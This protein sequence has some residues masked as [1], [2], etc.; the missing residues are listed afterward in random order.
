MAADRLFGLTAADVSSLAALQ[1][2]DNRPFFRDVRCAQDMGDYDRIPAFRGLREMYEFFTGDSEVSGIFNRR[3]LPVE[4]RNR[5]D[6]TSATFSFVMGN[7]L[8]RRLVAVYRDVKYREELLISIKKTVKD[9]RT[10]EAV[11][12]GGFPD[13]SDVD[14]EAADYVE[15][16]GVTD[17]ESTYTILQKGNLLII[18]RKVIINDDISVVQRL[19]NGLGRSARRSHGK[20]VWNFFINNSNCSDGTAWFT[21]PHGNLGGSALTHATALIAYVALAKMAEKDSGERIGLLDDPGVKPNLIG[22]IDLMTTI[23]Q[24]ATEDY[25]YTG[26]ADLT[27]KTPNPLRGKV[28]PV[29]LSL[30]TDTDDWGMILPPAVADVVEMGYLNG[31]EEPE[32]FVAD[33]PQSEQIFMA[34]KVRYK[35]RHEYAGAVI[36]FRPGY[37]AVV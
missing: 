32:M 23:E 29:V 21:N 12:V 20:Y 26:A 9:F 22:P 16:A 14:P 3:N 4:L 35:I 11:L 5:Q 17:E 30:L 8:A 31:R 7:T 27:T 19:V 10:Q 28:N 18:N 33:S 1:T 37:K 24:I 25:Y 13:L 15:I 36:D 34:D 6:I 2:L